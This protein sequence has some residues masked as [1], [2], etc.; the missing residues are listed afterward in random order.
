L[1]LREQ[2]RQL[3]RDPGP[4]LWMRSG[5]LLHALL[6]RLRRLRTTRFVP[7]PRELR[8]DVQQLLQYLWNRLRIVLRYRQR[9]PRLRRTSDAR[10]ERR[11]DRRSSAIGGTSRSSG[12]PGNHAD[13][14]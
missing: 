1:R 7:L 2:L 10:T 14:E 12:D 5:F 6:R 13:P 11:R 3:L 4:V 8:L 9:M